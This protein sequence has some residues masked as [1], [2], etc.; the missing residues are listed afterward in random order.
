MT[1]H[2]GGILIKYAVLFDRG[3]DLEDNDPCKCDMVF[4]VANSRFLEIPLS[5]GNG[6]SKH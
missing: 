6:H 4:H 2:D 5:I 3:H 1:A